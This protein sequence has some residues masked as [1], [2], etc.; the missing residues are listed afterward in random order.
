MA[1]RDIT[2]QQV[3]TALNREQRRTPGE[4]SRARSGF[5]DWSRGMMN[6]GKHAH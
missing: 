6:T 5:T 4:P 2:E 3:Y 1:R